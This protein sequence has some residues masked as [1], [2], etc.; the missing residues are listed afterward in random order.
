MTYYPDAIP[1]NDNY[2]DRIDDV[3]W[4]FAAR[5][6]EV[7]N[8]VLAICTELGTLPKGSYGSV[9]DRLDALSSVF[10]EIDGSN[11]NSN[12]DIGA[13]DFISTGDLTIGDITHVG[14]AGSN[15]TLLNSNQDKDIFIKVND[16]GVVKTVLSIDASEYETT[17][18]TDLIGANAYFSFVDVDDL[19]YSAD[20][21]GSTKVPTR[22]AI[23]DKIESLTAFDL[24]GFPADPNADRYL[25]WNDTSGA[26][27]WAEVSGGLA[28]V[29]DDLT[30]QLGGDLDCQEHLLDN[31]GDIYHDDAV[32]SDWTLQNEDQD[33]DILI[34]VNDG[35]ST[36]TAIQVHGDNGV[37][38]TAYQP[39]VHARITSDFEVAQATYA[40]VVWD[41]EVYDVG[42]CYNNAN[43]TFTAPEDGYYLISGHT[44][45]KNTN[46]GKYYY[47]FAWTG[48]YHTEYINDLIILSTNESAI[49]TQS[50]H[51][52]KM[53]KNETFVFRAYHNNS[54][55]EYLGGTGTGA[56]MSFMSIG[57]IA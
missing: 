4:I 45:W 44:Y 37:I 16:G 28:A 34:K 13:Y 52:R 25:K 22:N 31:V 46:S 57:K 20:W 14:A 7:K 56:R 32:A 8:E 40:T 21:N 3:D 11:A 48:T 5:Y 35:G 51:I 27:E 39:L 12:L 17:I 1:T 38:S 50:T 43:G 19:A 47:L 23:Y 55:S 30:P 41:T 33:K 9:K 36:I 2:P 54:G 10:L 29:V 24:D 42:G 53:D 49:M 26:L 6:N 15:W 18:L